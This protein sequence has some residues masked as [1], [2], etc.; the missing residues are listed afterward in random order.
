[1]PWLFMGLI[2]AAIVGW[3]ALT[4]VII[5]FFPP[6]GLLFFSASIFGLC[7]PGRRVKHNLIFVKRETSESVASTLSFFTPKVLWKPRL[8]AAIVFLFA[9]F[10]IRWAQSKFSDVGIAYFDGLFLFLFAVSVV[11]AVSA[12]KESKR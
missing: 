9:F 12:W 3:A 4:A 2:A 10:G 5:Y 11:L 7:D 1:M 6:V 8:F